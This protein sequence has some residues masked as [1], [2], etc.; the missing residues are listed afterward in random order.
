MDA[1]RISLPAGRIKIKHRDTKYNDTIIMLSTIKPASRSTPI[2][3]PPF[4]PPPRQSFLAVRTHAH[5]IIT[6]SGVS[7]RIQYNT[8]CRVENE[9]TIEYIT[10]IIIMLRGAAD[11]VYIYAPYRK[12]SH[13]SLARWYDALI[14]L[15]FQ[16]CACEYFTPPCPAYCAVA[17]QCL[18]VVGD[19]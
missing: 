13:K 4:H 6:S 8:V 9:H 2:P 14:V 7:A 11:S 15:K 12:L 1:R 3:S 18:H 17:L 16:K 5:I 10:V 19:R